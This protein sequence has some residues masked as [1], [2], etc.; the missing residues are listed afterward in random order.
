M[1]VLLIGVGGVGEA[2][3]VVARDRPWSEMMVLAD[4]NLERASTVQERLGS[5]EKFPIEQLDAR[6]VSQIIHLARKY[7]IDL[8]MNAVSNFYNDTIFDAAYEAGCNYLD[9]AMSDF[10]ANMGNHQWCQAPNGRKRI[11]GHPGK[12]HGP[13]G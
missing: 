12:W 11:A 5:P 4:Y 7:G 3:A 8:I 1:R 13:W 2:I 6:N 10:G 9:M